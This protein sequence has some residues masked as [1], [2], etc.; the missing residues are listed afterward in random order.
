[1]TT[2]EQILEQ[3]TELPLEQQEALSEIVKRRISQGRRKEL[4]SSSQEALT[5]FKTGNLKTLSATEAISELR[6]YL[7]SSF[8]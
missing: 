2:F 8:T 7:N 4:A 1:M 5:E 6:T 3:I